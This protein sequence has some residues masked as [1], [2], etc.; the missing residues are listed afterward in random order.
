MEKVQ[1][2]SLKAIYGYKVPYEDILREAGVD[3]L[4]DR[5]EQSFERFTRKTVKNPK[6]LHWFP[7]KEHHSFTRWAKNIEY[8]EEFSKT[9][10]TQSVSYTHLTLPTIYSV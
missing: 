4:E 1:K 9:S 2:K 6:F 7:E 3:K 5:R 10:S 8:L